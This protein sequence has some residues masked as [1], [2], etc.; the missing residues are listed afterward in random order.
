V[1]LRA[2]AASAAAST[3]SLGLA[4]MGSIF[5]GAEA[6]PTAVADSTQTVAWIMAGIMAPPSSS[7]RSASPSSALT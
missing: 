2:G 4:I 7:R 5:V 3:A 6:G 1:Q